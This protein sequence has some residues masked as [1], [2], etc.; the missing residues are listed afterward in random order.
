MP[1]FAVHAQ[2]EVKVEKVVEGL[3]PCHPW[4]NTRRASERLS[5]SPGEAFRTGSGLCSTVGEVQAYGDVGDHEVGVKPEHQLDF[6]VHFSVVPGDVD[7]AFD[8]ARCGF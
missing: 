2:F 7:W 6:M 3:V 5:T 8:E 1:K 4:P